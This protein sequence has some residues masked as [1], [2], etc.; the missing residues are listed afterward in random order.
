MKRKRVERLQTEHWF[1][2]L[3]DDDLEVC[4]VP[5]AGWLV[6]DEGSG[7]AMSRQR[8]ICIHAFVN[9]RNYVEDDG[10]EIKNSFKERV[11]LFS[12]PA[13]RFSIRAQLAELCAQ[14]DAG[15]ESAV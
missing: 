4:V 15:E 7:S 6:F 2:P 13:V 5:S 9:F 1:K 11:N 3:E 10:S 12:V 14:E 8:D